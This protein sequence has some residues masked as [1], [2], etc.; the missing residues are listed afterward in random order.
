MSD[1]AS[2]GH[3][4]TPDHTPHVTPLWVYLA[5]WGTLVVL[6]AI[7]VGASYIDIGGG[8]LIVALVIATIK[9][10]VV[11][12]MFMHLLHDQRYHTM[13]LLSGALF[14]L[15]FIGF[16]MFDTE[17]RG[18]ADAIEGERAADITKPFDGTKSLAA[19]KAKWKGAGAAA[20]MT[21]PQF[22]STAP[23]AAAAGGDKAKDSAA[24]A[25]GSVHAETPGATSSASAAPSVSAAPA[26]AAPAASA[27]ASASAPPG[28][29]SA[30]PHGSAHAH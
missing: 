27:P 22:T 26:P 17:Y 5:T 16:T 29:A 9:A 12:A 28:S 4:H 11:A 13:I 2:H 25:V 20:S 14:L 24:A 6:T 10:G 30:A 18:R 7:T 1:H 21:P 8:N 15:I 19:M 3:R 23:T